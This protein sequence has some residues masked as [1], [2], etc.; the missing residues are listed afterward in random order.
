V[1]QLISN[2]NELINKPTDWRATYAKVDANLTALLGP[3]NTDA[4]ST[5]GVSTGTTGTTGATAV[6]GSAGTAAGI[7]SLDPTVRAKLVDLRRQLND[8]AK[9]SGQGAGK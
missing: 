4:E 8:F 2:F 1:S 7:A 9:A 3:D 5:G 6:T